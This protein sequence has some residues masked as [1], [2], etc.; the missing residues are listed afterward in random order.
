MSGHIVER[1][2][3]SGRWAIVLEVGTAGQRRQKW[4]SFRGTKREAQKRLAELITERERGTY[5]EPSKQTVAQYFEVWLRDWA[6]VGASPRTCT[7]YAQLAAHVVAGLGSIPIQRV[8]GGD[9]NRLYRELAE[10]GLEPSGVRVIHRFARRVFGHAVKHGDLKADP[11]RHVDSPKVPHQEAAVLRA[12]EI[13]VLLN[14][15]KGKTLYP[16]AVLGLGTGMRLGELLAL[17]WQDVDLDGGKLEVKRSL[18]QHKGQLRFKEPKSKRGL[19]VISLAPSVIDCLR[20][21]RQTQLEL[22]MR[23]GLGKPSEDVLVFPT[24][25]GRPRMPN[26]LSKMFSDAM[27]KIGLPHVTMHTLRH[28][29]ASELIRKG[30]DILTISRRLGHSSAAITLGVYGHLMSSQDSAADVIEAML[31]IR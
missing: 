14:G 12:E 13:P 26:S 17:R 1:P 16:I 5:V 23:L 28:T 19:R 24:Y 2:K 30:V 18:E 8:S 27:V 3:G 21:H 15:L 6:P 25:D 4:H 20:E 22:R 11:S 10:K 31:T 9:L 7:R 29:H